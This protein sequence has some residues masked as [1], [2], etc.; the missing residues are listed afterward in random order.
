MSKQ[1][2]KELFEQPATTG[3]TKQ[4]QSAGSAVTCTG[5]ALAAPAP[6]PDWRQWVSRPNA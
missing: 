1:T 2:S 6:A 3:R 5:G 4:L